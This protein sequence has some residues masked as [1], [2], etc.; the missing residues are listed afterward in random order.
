V[1][2]HTL[3]E[4]ILELLT[5]DFNG[6]IHIAATESINR[7]ELSRRLA[8]QLGYPADK[9]VPFKPDE[10]SQNRAPRH[11]NG[12]ISVAKAQ[13]IL[14]I[15]MLSIEDTLVRALASNR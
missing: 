12:I 14:T 3:S 7:L 5:I 13:K 1:D 9:I 6:V 2:V 11:K 8:A 4:S 15:P 10:Q